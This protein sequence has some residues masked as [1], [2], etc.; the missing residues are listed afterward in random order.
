MTNQ[1]PEKKLNRRK[2]LLIYKDIQIEM[3]KIIFWSNLLTVMVVSGAGFIFISTVRNLAIEADLAYIP[4]MFAMLSEFIWI[5]FVY[6]IIG[7][8]FVFGLIFYAWLR[9]SNMIAG[10][11]YNIRRQLENYVRTG[12]FNKVVL[13]K[14][15]KI[16]DF[17]ELINESIQ[18]SQ[19]DKSDKVNK[20][21]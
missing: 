21:T 15:D 13:R 14:K 8:F 19:K 6:L 2:K 20:F 18:L 5:Y 7:V 3:F 11:L 9:I 10:P 16:Q 1:P 4:R 12:V 17:A